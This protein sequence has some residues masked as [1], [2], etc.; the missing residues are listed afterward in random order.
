VAGFISLPSGAYQPDPTA[1]MQFDTG[2]TRIHTVQT[3]VLYGDAGATYDPAYQRW[4]P[5]Q[6]AQVLPDGSAYAY[7]VEGSVPPLRNEIHVVTVA[8]GA[9]RIVYNQ[10]TYDAIAYGPEGIFLDFH[11]QGTDGS[12]GLWMLNPTSG[13][14]TGFQAGTQSWWD[15]IVDGGAWSYSV[16]GNIFGSST[17]NRLDLSSGNVV[18]WF[19]AP[20]SPKPPTPGYKTVQ[21][22]GFDRSGHPISLQNTNGDASQTWLLSAPG[23]ATQLTGLPISAYTPQLGEMDSHGTW[24]AGADGLYLYTDAGF[25]RVAPNPPGWDPHYEISSACT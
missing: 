11:P 10:G 15:V 12:H 14:V 24:I 1:H 22:I 17:L 18:T 19:T 4:L 16:D 23:H 6:R 9:D 7:T 13:K 3:P 2:R 25:Q 8:T 5:V 21:V 20:S